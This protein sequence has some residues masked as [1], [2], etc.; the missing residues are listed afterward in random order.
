MGRIDFGNEMMDQRDWRFSCHLR[1]PVSCSFHE[2]I[3]FSLGFSAP[4]V[5]L[6]QYKKLPDKIT[7]YKAIRNVSGR[8]KE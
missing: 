7:T 4:T 1:A 2:A 8:K 5:V 6:R 3:H